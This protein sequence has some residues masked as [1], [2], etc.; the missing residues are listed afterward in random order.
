[1]LLPP[2]SGTY[3]AGVR[4]VWCKNG[5]SVYDTSNHELKKNKEQPEWT[6]LQVSI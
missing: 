4:F 2:K 3:S 1:M 6:F 5:L